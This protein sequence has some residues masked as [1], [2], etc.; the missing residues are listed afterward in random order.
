MKVYGYPQTRSTRILWML[1]EIGVDY[2]FI[3]IDLTKGEGQQPEYKKINPTGKVPAVVDGDFTL[4]ESAA[5]CTY[6]GDK[7]PES[8]L[9]P[10]PFSK[11]RAN[12]N[13]W[14]FYALCELE[15]PLWTMAKHGWI[16]P[17]DKRVP[18]IVDTAIWEFG[19]AGK[20]LNDILGHQEYIL[21]DYFSAADILIAHCCGWARAKK[22]PIKHSTLKH[23][24]TR[25]LSRPAWLRA[26]EREKSTA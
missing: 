25:L 5:I 19:V 6:L 14:C 8:K 2:E 15:Q 9:V 16:L 22:I 3:Q 20:V 12:Y 26:R 7:Y 10:E 18:A 24:S 11:D 23:Y 4:W 1:E 17:E 13:K 21:G